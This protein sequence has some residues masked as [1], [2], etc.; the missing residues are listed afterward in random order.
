MDVMPQYIKRKN[1]TE[2][3]KKKQKPKQYIYE[4]QK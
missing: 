3:R 4:D 2:R 1:T